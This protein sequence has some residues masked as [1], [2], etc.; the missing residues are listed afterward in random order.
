MAAGDITLYKKWMKGQIDGAGLSSVPV[1][2]DTDTIKVIILKNTHTPDASA[3]TTQEH[4][5]DISA[6]EVATATAYTGAI[7]LGSKTVG[8]SGSVVTFDAADINIAADAGG[9]TDGRHIVIYKDTGTPSTSPLIATG[10]LGADKSLQTG[11]L[12][13]LWGAGGIITWTE[14]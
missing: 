5:D 13:F 10:D 6:D 11:S 12:D 4:L 9:F 8:V 1:D 2:F 7:T 14:V 3:S